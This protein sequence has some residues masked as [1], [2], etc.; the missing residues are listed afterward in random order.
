MA[1]MGPPPKAPGTRARRNATMPTTTLPAIGRRGKAPAWP[2]RSDPSAQLKRMVAE[3]RAERLREELND[4]E[5]RRR[6][7][8]LER[9]LDAALAEAEMCALQLEDQAAMES[10]LWVELWGTPQAA[11][12][13][14][15]AWYRDVAQYVR[16]KIRA[17]LGD[18]DAAK[19]ARQWSDRLGL[20]PL[21][22]L[23]LRWEIER[24][25]SAEA[26]GRARRA[27]P[28]APSKSKSQPRDPRSV[29]R[30]V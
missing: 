22:L 14:K 7:G 2:L 23:R 26:E 11:M 3:Q 30:A 8:R 1:G 18:L 16:H 28:K 21:A 25:D 19:E 27:K 5:D 13:E 4:C 29:L 20:N 12:W 24:T 6:I 9:E 17:E 10:E 15:L